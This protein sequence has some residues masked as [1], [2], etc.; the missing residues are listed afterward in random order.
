HRGDQQQQRGQSVGDEGDPEGGRPAAHLQHQGPVLVG[1]VQQHPGV[2]DD[3]PEHQQPDEPL[4]IGVAAEDQ[5]QPGSRQRQDHRQGY[6]GGHCVASFSSSSSS[7]S[8]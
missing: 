2:D 5:R 6:Q 7:S 1:Q 3:Q 4:G 8:S